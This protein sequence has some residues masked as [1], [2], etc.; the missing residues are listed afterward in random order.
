MAPDYKKLRLLLIDC[1]EKQGGV[2]N[3]QFDWNLHCFHKYQNSIIYN[4][5]LNQ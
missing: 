2:L 4:S 5:S 3:N 1:L